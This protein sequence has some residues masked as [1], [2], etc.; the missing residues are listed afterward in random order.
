MELV[1]MVI[2]LV[3]A[4]ANVQ[5]NEVFRIVLESGGVNV[6]QLQ[7]WQETDRIYFKRSC[8]AGNCGI[9]LVLKIDNVTASDFAL[10]EIATIIF[11]SDPPIYLNDS[12]ITD[13]G[14]VTRDNILFPWSGIYS[15]LCM[16]FIFPDDRGCL[17]AYLNRLNANNRVTEGFE[18]ECIFVYEC[19]STFEDLPTGYEYAML[20]E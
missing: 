7:G 9:S 20:A 4:S 18:M 2:V 3:N 10:M 12:W 11:G 19:H 15:D 17:Q 1:T 5:S 16:S 8:N 6:T 14:T 13:V